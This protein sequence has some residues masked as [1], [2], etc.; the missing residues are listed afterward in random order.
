MNKDEPGNKSRS[1]GVAAVVCIMIAAAFGAVYGTKKKNASTTTPSTTENLRVPLMEGSTRLDV[2]PLQADQIPYDPYPAIPDPRDTIE[3]RL[4]S[5]NLDQNMVEGPR[6][7][8]G[9]RRSHLPQA[10]LDS[11]QLMRDPRDSNMDE[12]TFNE[13][14]RRLGGGTSTNHPVSSL[15]DI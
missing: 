9:Y 3:Q 6:R 14:M 10:T 7:G 4:R 12:G 15:H 8:L 1:W 5:Q 2:A 11:R 13:Y